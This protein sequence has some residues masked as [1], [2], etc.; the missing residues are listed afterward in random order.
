MLSEG[1]RACGGARQGARS[2]LKPPASGVLK[3]KSL[4]GTVEGR[5]WQGSQPSTCGQ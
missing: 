3:A 5:R 2:I 4:E 1:G